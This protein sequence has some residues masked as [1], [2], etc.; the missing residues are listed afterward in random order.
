MLERVPTFHSFMLISQV[1]KEKKKNDFDKHENMIYINWYAK[2]I[3]ILGLPV[4]L[5]CKTQMSEKL[6]IFCYYI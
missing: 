2:I 3:K 1:K 4:F 5:M 6:I